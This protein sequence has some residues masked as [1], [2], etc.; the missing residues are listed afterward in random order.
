[1]LCGIVLF[2]ES[3]IFMFTESILTAD[4]GDISE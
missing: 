2:V 4:L 1:M 3:F